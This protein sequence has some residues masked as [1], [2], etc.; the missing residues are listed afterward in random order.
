MVI[1]QQIGLSQTFFATGSPFR[2]M[3][4]SNAPSAAPCRVV[5]RTSA[6]ADSVRPYLKQEGF[7]HVVMVPVL[8]KKSV[9]GTLTLGSRHRLCYT[10]DDLEFLATS[11]HQLGLAVENLRLVEQILRSHRQWANTFDSIQDLVLLHDS[12]FRMMKA[13]QALLQRLHRRPPMSSANPAKRCCRTIADSG[14]AAPTA[15]IAEEGFHEG[16]DPCFGGFSMVSTS[17]YSEQGSKQKGTIHV[18]RDTTDRRVAEEKYRLL[19]EQ[20]QE[21][22]FVATPDGKLLDCNDA[23]V[24]MLG[25]SNRE[26]LMALNLDTE[27]YASAEQRDVFRREIELHNFVRNFEVTL[28]R[29][30]GTLLTAME[31]SFATRDAK[32]R[33][34][35]TRDSCS[36]SPRKNAPRT[37]SAAATAN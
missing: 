20:V 26:E 1:A 25:Y 19:F 2:W 5:A 3:T 16:P 29:K 9:I 15:D 18:V 11:A 4:I 37:K 6:A 13:N 36:T 8:G 22:V 17:S 35:A 12:E 32:A 21:G 30:D 14:K 24:R 28:R 34:S 33:S 23:F 27:L 31:S 7:H 10:P